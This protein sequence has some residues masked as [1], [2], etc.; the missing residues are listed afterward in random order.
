MRSDHH[1]PHI[2]KLDG[3]TMTGFGLSVQRSKKPQQIRGLN[4]PAT[5]CRTSIT[6]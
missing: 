4:D 3:A 2:G 1:I 5:L 6:L